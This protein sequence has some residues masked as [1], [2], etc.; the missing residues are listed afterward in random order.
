MKSFKHLDCTTKALGVA[1]LAGVVMLSGC[2]TKSYKSASYKHSSS[3]YAS[4]AP[5]GNYSAATTAQAQAQTPTPTGRTEENAKNMVVPLYQ[6][7]VNVGKREVDSGTVRLRKVVKTETVNQPI[8]LR[9]EELVIERENGAAKG[10][11]QVLAQP[12]QEQETVIRLKREEPVIEKQ[13]VPAGAVTVQTRTTQEQRNIQAEVRREDID[14]DKHGAQNV[15]IGQN[16]QGS[17]RV[18]NSGAGETATGK[19]AGSEANMITSPDQITPENAASYNGW[20]VRFSNAKVDQVIGDRLIVLN[21]N[22]GQKVYV[23]SNE[24]E[25]LKCKKGDTVMVTGTVK[26]GSATDAGLS[27]EAAQ[28]LSNRQVYIQAQNVQIGGNEGQNQDK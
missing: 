18:E 14:I 28:E 17:A 13:T 11:E 4:A 1:G 23:V 19:G 10:G 12:F 20:R 3:S 6:E 9:R 7:N 2:C 5:E 27:G 21:A 8:E 16:V 15:T 22:N 24:G 26:A 25:N